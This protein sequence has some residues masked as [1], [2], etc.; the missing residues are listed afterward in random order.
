MAVI[1][2]GIGV[3]NKVLIGDIGGTNAR[4]AIC[5][6]GGFD[7]LYKFKSADFNNLKDL[8][9]HYYKE[10][11]IFE[12]PH[13]AVIAVAGKVAGDQINLTNVG[14]KFSIEESRKDL[15]LKTLKIINDLEAHAYYIPKLD[16]SE[17]VPL[18]E[19]REHKIG[20]IGVVASGT[21]LGACVLINKERTLSTEAGHMSIGYI[22]EEQKKI[23]ELMKSENAHVR[24]EDLTS[25]L[26]L[27]N[28]Y[29]KLC[30]DANI[31]CKYKD[32]KEVRT[33]ALSGAAIPEKAFK[34]AL[35]FLGIFMSDF[36]LTQNLD[37]VYFISKLANTNEEIDF[38]R[39]S[40]FEKS[41]LSKGRFAH[42]M[43]KVPV[44][45]VKTKDTGLLGLANYANLYF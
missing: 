23:Y 18:T 34:L 27:N 15:S 2:T 4:L 37:A 13:L 30:E 6:N 43:E 10:A 14:M 22:T 11:E 28:I 32:A 42:A 3:M 17:I 20:R 33:A 35:E 26:A 5:E 39:S 29:Q 1:Q 16:E 9:N 7:Q 12:K 24:V 44:Y 8:I 31:E 38:I 25:V 45:A 21:G 41:F 40:F 36:A 19:V